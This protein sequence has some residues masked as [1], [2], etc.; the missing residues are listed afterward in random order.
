MLSHAT[1]SLLTQKLEE[2]MHKAKTGNFATGCDLL[3]S[4]SVAFKVAELLDGKFS[5]AELNRTF[6]ALLKNLRELTTQHG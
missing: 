3:L 1:L 6:G 2:V 5:D 4:L